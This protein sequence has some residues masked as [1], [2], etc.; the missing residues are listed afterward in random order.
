VLFSLPLFPPSL[1]SI[2]SLCSLPFLTSECFSWDHG[3]TCLS[4]SSLQRH[5]RTDTASPRSFSS[6]T[7]ASI[8]TPRGPAMKKNSWHRHP[9]LVHSPPLAR[10]SPIVARTRTEHP[11]I[12]LLGTC[13]VSWGTPILRRPVCRRL[14]SSSRTRP[15][16][17]P[18]PTE[19]SARANRHSP[20]CASRVDV[21][22]L[23]NKDARTQRVWA[24]SACQHG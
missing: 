15:P 12:C 2:P 11:L 6:L 4:H 17:F 22:S 13:L 14:T 23:A 10:F 8:H 19:A 18:D 7:V 21:R 9:H 3:S 1:P 24:C 20:G 16:T 5:L